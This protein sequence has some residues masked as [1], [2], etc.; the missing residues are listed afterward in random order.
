MSRLG[1]T[2]IPL[3]KGVKVKKIDQVVEAEG[4]KGVLRVS[5]AE[6][7]QIH[8][9]EELLKVK[10]DEAIQ[11]EKST[12]GLYRALIANAITGVHIGFEKQLSLVGVGYRAAVK[13]S[14]LD[15]QV[16]FSHPCSL[17]IPE[18]LQVQ[19]E[20][21]TLI[22][23]WGIDKRIVGEFAAHVRKIRPPEPYKGKG[24]RYVGEYVRKKA[25]KAAKGK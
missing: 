8:I 18:G 20:K 2:P 15:L 21:N 14:V 16:G 17:N 23:I 12:H 24:I 5:V 7:I 19:V 3:P 6:G 9:Q 4:P 10:I 25:G 1:N 13:G 11:L 22:K